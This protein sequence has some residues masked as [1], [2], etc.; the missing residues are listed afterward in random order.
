MNWFP[1]RLHTDLSFLQSFIKPKVATK[2][3]ADLMYK[4]CAITDIDSVSGCVDFYKSCKESGIKPILGCEF[5]NKYIVLAKNLNGWKKLMLAVSDKNTEVCYGNDHICISGYYGSELASLI[6]APEAYSAES[7]EHAKSFLIDNW[8]ETACDYIRNH[9]KLFGDSFFVSIEKMD[10]NFH[11]ANVLAECFVELDK[12]IV[13][14]GIETII[15][16]SNDCRYVDRED[17]YCHRILLCSHQKT[18]IP[19]INKKIQNHVSFKDR[20]FFFSGCYSIPSSFD[21]EAKYPNHSGDIFSRIYDICEDYNILSDP[22][23]PSFEC[24]GGIS[25]IEYLK[26]LCRDGWKTRLTP[27]Q[28]KSD[29]YI[30]RMRDEE[31]PVIEEAN[32]AGYFLIVQDVVNYVRSRGWLPG[33]GRGSAAGC[34][35]SYLIKITGINPIPFDLLF[36]RFYNASRKGSLPDIDIDVPSEHRDEVIAYIKAKYGEDKVAQMVTYGRLQG[37]SAVKEVMRVEG[38]VSFAE[39]NEITKYIPD[40]AKIADQLEEME[41]KSILR[42][43]LINNAK[44]LSKWCVLNE[45]GTLSGDLADTF[46]TAMKIEGTYKNQGKHAAA[47]V[48]A[49]ESLKNFCPMIEDKDGNKIAGFEMSDLDAVGILKLDVLGVDILSKV[50]KIAQ[51]KNLDINDFSDMNVWDKILC[52]GDTQGIFQLE[53]NLGKTWSKRLK[54]KQLSDLSDLIAI[55]RPGCSQ[56]YINGESLTW[57]YIKRR[58]NVYPVT[59][60][61]PSLEPILKSTYGILVYQEQAMLIAREIAG[62]SEQEADSLRKAIGKKLPE[63]MAKLK[64]QFLDGCKKVGKVNEQDAGQIF[65]WIEA[66]QRYSFNKSHSVAYAVN[67]FWSAYCKYHNQEK[68][69]EVYLEHSSRKQDSQEEISLLV[70]DAKLHGIEVAPASLSNFN[71]GFLKTDCNKIYFGIS[72]IKDVGATECKKLSSYLETSNVKDLTWMQILLEFAPILNKKA[73]IAMASTGVFHGKNN[74]TFRNRMIYEYGIWRN[75]SDREITYIKSIFNKDKDLLWHIDMLISGLN[76]TSNRLSTVV[77]LKRILENPTQRLEDEIA[78]IADEEKKYYGTALTFNKA[79]SISV[80]A[81]TASCKD[82]FNCSIRGNVRLAVHVKSVREHKTKDGENMAFLC[83]E[84]SSASIDSVVV[85]PEAFHKYY[86]VLYE[87]NTVIING[88]P[89]VKNDGSLIVESVWQV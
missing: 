19:E 31:L 88:K 80:D 52:E 11:A 24:P 76:I 89:S 8:K 34:L 3:C 39:M 16:P 78:W 74:K 2:K 33:P 85:F 65:D 36:S 5:S 70:S 46:K 73:F 1:V 30:S 17:S 27:E 53:S 60:L 13:A 41:D 35:I 82:V 67:A 84:D 29:Q 45:D 58:N 75:L 86:G 15:I 4:A 23:L 6:L 87:G 14:Q 18:T 81:A 62:F 25:E 21:I 7:F 9:R 71:L 40:E 47:V 12:E 49:P 32:L 10:D 59:Y 55:I 48:I 54:P 63:L 61:H 66:S 28:R 77:G 20:H 43:S 44:S 51:D 83:I 57:H 26:E 68:F 22:M 37:R 42:W 79:D 69:Y 50:M 72:H 56:S 38:N 64:I